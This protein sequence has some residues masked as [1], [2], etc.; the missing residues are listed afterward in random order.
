M[1]NWCN[2]T[3]TLSHPDK[4]MMEKAI[5]AT[6]NGF[7]Q[8]LI[9]CPKELTDTIKGSVGLPYHQRLL[10][11]KQ[12]LNIE[13]FGHAT[14]YEWALENWGTKWDISDIEGVTQPDS[15]IIVFQSAW[16][17]PTKAYEK[18]HE[19]GFNVHA[20]Y[21]EGGCAFCGEWKD[22]QDYEYPLPETIEEL[23]KQVPQNI[24]E[25]FNIIEDYKS[26]TDE[27]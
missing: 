6:R 9:P 14:W 23:I 24:I 27:S 8:T 26:M 5:E 10:E 12:Q 17:P 20:Y 22:G 7:L 16:S 19:M 18:L 4:A 25:E 1:P 13:F 2:N 3:L 11:F 21:Y 15:F